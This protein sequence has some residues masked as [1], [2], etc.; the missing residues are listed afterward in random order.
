M[1][2]VSPQNSL[3]MY[4]IFEIFIFTHDSFS[5]SKIMFVYH[6]WEGDFSLT[7]IIGAL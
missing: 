4:M 6:C 7:L 3:I 1:T 5:Y 2:T